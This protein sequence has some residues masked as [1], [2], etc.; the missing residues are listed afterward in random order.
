MVVVVVL[1][2]PLPLPT[3]A[4]YLCE[5]I[6]NVVDH[7][8]YRAY[9]KNCSIHTS[10]WSPGS[11]RQ[12]RKDTFTIVRVG[13]GGRIDGVDCITVPTEP[14]WGLSQRNK[15]YRNGRIGQDGG[16]TEF[17]FDFLIFLIF[18]SFL[19]CQRWSGAGGS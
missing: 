6:V 7:Q 3:L 10:N 14:L 8:G 19:L 1:V 11:V 17:M 18:R 16:H 2:L 5:G 12:V 9:S 4:S 13:R 15:P